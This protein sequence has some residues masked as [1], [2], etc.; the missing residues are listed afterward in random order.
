MELKGDFMRFLF[1]FHHNGKLI[2]GFKS[3]YIT[4]IPKVKSPQP[5]ANFRPI[6]LVGCLHKVIANVLANR[7]RCVKCNW[8]CNIRPPISFYL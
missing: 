4:L 8:W 7:L 1:E 5:L 3:T 2:K 6:S